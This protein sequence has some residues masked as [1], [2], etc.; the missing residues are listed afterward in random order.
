[1]T[2]YRLR[3]EY[4]GEFYRGFQRLQGRSRPPT[5]RSK[6][7]RKWP[8]QSTVQEELEVKLSLILREEIKVFGAGRTD[9]GVHATGQV[10]SFETSSPLPPE[11]W[12]RSLNAVLHP[13]VCVSDCQVV[14]GD[15]H[16]RFS[17]TARLYHYYV[18]PQAPAA[19]P[20]FAD[21]C[22]LLPQALEVEAMRRAAAPLLGSHDFSAYTRG[23]EPH[24]P[25]RRRLL[26]LDILEDVLAPRL[27][28]GP[29]A[30]LGGLLCF[31]ISANAFLRRMVRQLVANLL[32]VGTG[33]WPVERPAQI[34]ASRDPTLSAPP[35]PAHGLYLVGVDFD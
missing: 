13:G 3:V 27:A 31:E 22:W 30:A 29:W 8:P 18:W 24:E 4:R 1:M 19:N 17:A 26:R 7:P 20:F 15:F 34:L 35:A 33:E 11:S 6:N 14:T 23:P 21:L 28:S 5:T 2:R 32:K 9:T 16:P 25:M 12:V 10:V